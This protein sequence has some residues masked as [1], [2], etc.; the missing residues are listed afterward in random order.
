MTP[1]LRNKILAVLEKL[2]ER[3]T[4]AEAD[5]LLAEIPAL[6]ADHCEP[7]RWGLF[8]GWQSWRPESVM[9]EW[10]E[11]GAKDYREGRSNRHRTFHEKHP[12]VKQS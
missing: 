11:A 1:A 6:S 10:S 4:L 3:A 9:Q 2:P 5:D 7:L 8:D 12:K